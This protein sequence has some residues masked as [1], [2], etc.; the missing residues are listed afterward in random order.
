MANVHFRYGFRTHSSGTLRFRMN[1]IHMS[2]AFLNSGDGAQRAAS[3]RRTRQF[4]LDRLTAATLF[5][6]VSTV[7]ATFEKARE[8]FSRAAEGYEEMEGKGK[9]K[10][11]RETIED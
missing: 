2:K 8:R 10:G 11:K 1:A 4:L 9:G 5:S 7:M 3:T 6:S